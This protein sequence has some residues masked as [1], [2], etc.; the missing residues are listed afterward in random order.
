MA[1]FCALVLPVVTKGAK[2]C[3][4]LVISRLFNILTICMLVSSCGT[5]RHVAPVSNL[6][7][8]PTQKL[9]IHTVARGETLYSIAWRYNLEVKA[10]ALRN[11]IQQPFV[12]YPGQRLNLDTKNVVSKVADKSTKR[13]PATPRSKPQT[14]SPK[15]IATPSQI[16]KG[17]HW[18]WPATGAV[19]SQFGDKQALNKGIDIAAKKGEPVFAAESGTVVYAGEGLRGYGK[20]LIIKHSEDFLSAYAHNSK[21][22]VKEGEI[23]KARQKIAEIGS[24]GTNTNKLHF[25]IRRDGKPVDP[26]RFLPKR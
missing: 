5:Q 26:M 23:I 3:G 6:D 18:H 8:P 16:S 14:K 19:I 11:G 24:S 7:Q 15:K 13:L 4:F 22:L 25:E 20:L 12:I 1:N 2:N 10:L 21:L 17:L 9:T